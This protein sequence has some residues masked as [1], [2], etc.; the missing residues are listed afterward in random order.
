M[1]PLDSHLSGISAPVSSSKDVTTLLSRAD[2]CLT[3]GDYKAAVGHLLKVIELDPANT[4]AHFKWG[5]ALEYLGNDAEALEHYDAIIIK[6]TTVENIEIQKKAFLKKHFITLK[7]KRYDK[8][9]LAIGYCKKA[10]ELDTHYLYAQNLMTETL[11]LLHDLPAALE[12]STRAL[13]IAG[14]DILANDKTVKSRAHM[15]H[16]CLLSSLAG[17]LSRENKP[18]E[19]RSCYKNALKSCQDAIASNSE[20]SFYHN[21]MAKILYILGC[22]REAIEAS[23]RALELSPK[24]FSAH[25]NKITAH[26]ELNEISLAESCAAVALTAC[27]QQKRLFVLQ[28]KLLARKA[29]ASD[30]S[31]DRENHLN[32]A[33]ECCEKALL[34]DPSYAPAL[35]EKDT[36][37]NKRRLERSLAARSVGALIGRTRIGGPAI[38]SVGRAEVEEAAAAGAG[39]AEPIARSHSETPAACIKP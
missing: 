13:E 6:R 39:A 22:Y 10:L 36:L 31:T 14:L 19:A 16:S 2:G 24:L 29:D 17:K 27:P 4:D 26:L 7:S 38:I 28:A 33:L 25:F 12:A 30:N 34:L 5:L 32:A 23:T 11:L 35:E 15:N 3:G 37:S 8:H 9:E 21:E 18:D 1:R 20:D